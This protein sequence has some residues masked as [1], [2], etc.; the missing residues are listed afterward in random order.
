MLS[1]ASLQGPDLLTATLRCYDEQLLRK[2]AARL[3]RPRNQWPVDELINRS[4]ET[5]NNPAVL[6]RRLGELEPAGRQLLALIGHSRQPCWALGNLVELMMALGQ[7]DG[8]KPV[9][10][11]LEAGLLYPLLSPLPS[12]SDGSIPK[13]SRLVAFEQWLAAAGPGGLTVFALPQVA[14]RAIGADLGLPDLS[15]EDKVTRWQGDKVTEETASS[16]VTLSPPHLVTLSPMESD[17]LE[18]LLRLSVLWQQVFSAPLRRTQQG[19]F[20]KRDLERLDQDPLLN[21]PSADRLVDVPD[22]GFLLTALAHL[23]GILQEADGELRAG[24]LPA[25]WDEG[26]P[27]ALDTLF[28]DLFAVRGWTPLEG[29]KGVGAGALSGPDVIGNPFPSAYLLALLLLAKLP[30]NAWVKAESVENWLMAQHPYWTNESARPSRLAPWLETFLLG[31]AFPL[32][33]VQATRDSAGGLHQVRLS[34]MGRWLLG[35]GPMPEALPAF[36]RTLLVQPNLEIIAYRQGLTPALIG[37]LTHFASWKTLGAACTL[38]LEPETVYR[39]LESGET[40]DSIRGALEQHGTRATPPAVLDLLRTWSNKRD[41]ITVYPAAALMEFNTPEDLNEALARGLP[42][43]RVADTVAVVPSE[44]AIEYRHFRLTGTRDYALPPE[45]CVSVEPDGVTLTVDLARSDLMLETEL[46]R[47]AEPLDRSS[48]NGKRQYRLTPASLR[49]SEWTLPTLEAWFQQR[50]GQPVSA[51]AR[52]LLT[53]PQ[54]PP[55]SLRKHLVLHV[56]APEIADGLMQWPITRAL[57]EER[58]GPTSLSV[59][60]ENLDA[61]RQRLRAL[62]VTVE[63]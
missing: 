51:A 25:S 27:Q 37:R 48:A 42:G 29:W 18:W 5:L 13:S 19:G 41:R 2:V 60:D 54:G 31:V 38:Q 34:P 3:V 10:D 15:E 43:I 50:A 6:D 56:A 63:E 35:V 33:L 21:G 9:F 30:E 24:N 46:P 16:S 20:F 58:L 62:G 32:R 1:R 4:V 17:G 45:R 47:F 59:A 14:N 61:L 49:S 44:D 52:L 8:L 55:A 7:D 11:L 22:L 12:E 40:F 28:G 57:I 39:A 53:G 23:E 26:L 36:P